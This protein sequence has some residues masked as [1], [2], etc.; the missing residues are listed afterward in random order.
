MNLTLQ[1]STSSQIKTGIWEDES[2]IDSHSIEDRFLLLYFLT[3]PD[4]HLSGI[5]KLNYRIITSHTGWDK[6]HVSIVIE[7]LQNLGS[8]VIVENYLWMKQYYDHNQSPA[9]SHFKKIS[10]RLS[11]IPVGLLNDWIKDAVER[12]IPV[13]KII[14][15]PSDHPPMTPSIPPLDSLGTHPSN[16]NNN[17]NE[18][19]ND[20]N[21]NNVVSDDLLYPSKLEKDLIEP[22]RKLIEGRL[23]AQDL[24]DELAAKLDKEKVISPVSFVAGIIKNGLS[25]SPGGLLK[26]KN[27]KNRKHFG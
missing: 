18:N 8:I 26:E 25:K 7:R 1:E 20:K 15:F 22:M 2:F 14:I 3:C 6:Q 9:E 27:R 23:D 17:Y 21:N 12:G 16:S 11:E 4:R 5:I 19:F 13:D 10:N 24:L